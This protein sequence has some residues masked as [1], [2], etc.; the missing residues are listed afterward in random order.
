MYYILRFA[1]H[2][3]IFEY[4]IFVNGHQVIKNGIVWAWYIWNQNGSLMSFSNIVGLDGGRI[5]TR[6][7]N[8]V[9]NPSKQHNILY[10]VYSKP[11]H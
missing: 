1:M 2:G 10:W 5:H 7:L 8:S 11:Q 6:L 4:E 3:I 9:L